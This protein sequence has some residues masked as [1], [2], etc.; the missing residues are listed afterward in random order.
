MLK[1]IIF[2]DGAGYGVLIFEQK[3]EK[4]ISDILNKL[5]EFQYRVN[6]PPDTPR[7]TEEL[8]LK[9]L[10]ETNIVYSY[11]KTNNEYGFD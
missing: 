6:R 4:Q 8:L 10:S 9:R 2:D 7:F 5:T 11:I 3:Y 1:A